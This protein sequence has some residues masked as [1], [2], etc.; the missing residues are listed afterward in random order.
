MKRLVYLLTALASVLLVLELWC[1]YKRA[2]CYD[3]VVLHSKLKKVIIVDTR[4]SD[5]YKT[6][7]I[8]K[9]IYRRYNHCYVDSTYYS[10]WKD[11][12]LVKYWV[13]DTYDTVCTK[14]INL[15]HNKGKEK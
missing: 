2:H 5:S 6:F 4:R 1:N 13:S 14:Y 10:Y 7:G 3:K 12:I 9:I 15:N 11:S 8:Y